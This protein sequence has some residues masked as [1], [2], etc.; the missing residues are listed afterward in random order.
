[1]K[2]V[3]QHMT[4]CSDETQC[5]VAHCVSSRQI[6]Q[7]WRSCNRSDCPVCMPLKNASDKQKSSLANETTY[8]MSLENLEHEL[9]KVNSSM[10]DSSMSHH[11]NGSMPGPGAPGQEM[12][13]SG[14]TATPQPSNDSQ[15]AISAK[16]KQLQQQLVLLLHAHNCQRREQSNGEVDRVCTLMYCKTMKDV[17][18]HMTVCSDGTQCQVAHCVTS[19]QIIEHWRSCNRSDCPVC[20]P[21]K[22]AADKKKSSLANETM[23][24]M[25]L[26]NSE[27]ELDKVNSSMNDS[28]MSH[29]GNGSMPGPGAPGQEMI[30]S[31]QIATPQSSNVS[32]AAISAKRKRLQQQLVLLLHAHKCQRREQSNGEVARVCTLMYCKTMKD[33]LQ[34]MMVCSDGTQCQVAHCVTSRQIIEHWQSCNGSDC[35]VCSP[36]KSASHKQK[37]SLANET[38]YGMSLE[39]LEHELD[40]L[41]LDSAI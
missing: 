8:G 34:H 2:D 30:G 11:G 14:Q 13:S 5:Q 4:V 40:K 26:E 7:H 32:Q 38:M 6:I 16:R 18:Q 12:I 22:S 35:P 24:G 29:H 3:L 23:Y 31:G 15:A 37:S 21:L 36:L 41:N 9:D 39:D 25:S 19:R 1:M 28:S 10:N 27:H 20:L 17:L 33:V